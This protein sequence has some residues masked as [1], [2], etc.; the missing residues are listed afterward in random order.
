M[1]LASGLCARPLRRPAQTESCEQN[2]GDG[3]GLVALIHTISSNPAAVK[4]GKAR[5]CI[6]KHQLP[7]SPLVGSTARQPC[8]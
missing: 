6:S 5:L 4:Q 1:R 3:P 2:Y 7:A 8:S